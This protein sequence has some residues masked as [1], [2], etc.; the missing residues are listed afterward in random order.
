MQSTNEYLD[1]RFL[2][3]TQLSFLG[4]F[5]EKFNENAFFSVC[6]KDS[7]NKQVRM[8][9]RICAEFWGLV[10][11][12]MEGMVAREILTGVPGFINVEEEL[13]NIEE[14]EYKAIASDSQS[15]F[16]QTLLSYS[17]SVQIRQ[18]IIVP[19]YGIHNKLVATVGM[20]IDLTPYVNLLYLLDLYKY[21]YPNKT[22]AAHRFVTYFS[23]DQYF[24]KPL[25]YEELRTLLAM[26][27]D[28]RHKQVAIALEI[29]SKTVSSYLSSIRDKLK[30]NLTI[31]N[32][33]LHLKNYFQW[34][35][36]MLEKN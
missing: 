5:L 36:S 7:K 23:L 4:D 12:G 34:N 25:C 11:K 28:P 31:Y 8:N 20:A 17:G 27:R 32:L 10:E 18:S 35:P 26:L 15:R 13:Q 22:H 29:S 21:Y 14:N 24:H 6:V 30:P 9:N 3:P 33:L 2:F 16:T 1:N 19:L